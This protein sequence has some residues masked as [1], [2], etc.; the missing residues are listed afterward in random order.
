MPAPQGLLAEAWLRTPD[1]TWAR[2]QQDVS[3]VVGL[4]PPSAAETVVALTGLDARLGKLVDGASTWYAVAAS[5]GSTAEVGWAAALPLADPAL[6]AEALLD[7]SDAR[8]AGPGARTVAGM[9]VIEADAGAAPT[10]ALAGKWLVVASSESDLA[11]LGPYAFRTMPTKPAPGAAPVVASVPG[12]ALAGVVATQLG[13][14]WE[15]MRSWLQARDE[16]QRAA[17][18][19]RAPD[20]GDPRAILDAADAVVKRRIAVVGTASAARIELATEDGDVRADFSLT[21]GPDGGDA[22]TAALP[23]GTAHPLAEAPADAVLVI[24]SRDDATRRADDARELEVALDRALGSRA[25]ADDT[26]AVHAAIDDWARARG[27]WVL[28]SLEWGGEGARGLWLRT[29]A[30]SAEGASRAVRELVDLSHRHA[31]ESLLSGALHVAPSVVAAAD[32]ASVSRASLATFAASGADKHPH[33]SPPLGVAWGLHDGDLLVAAGG[34]A[35]AMLAAQAAPAKRLGDDP[36]TA[37]LVE[38]LGA[39][40]AFA[41]IARPLRLDPARGAGD[42]GLA[43]AV[44]AWGRK[45]SDAWV[46]VELGG[47]LIRELVRLKAGL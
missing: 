31:L 6:A 41:L 15:A 19:G 2:V 22:G 36:R 16:E 29:P 14:K 20:F 4:L 24:L 45:G 18:G 43:P 10:V 32:V 46:R 13:A 9:H 30:A 38:S 25:H 42:A 44:L 28:A 8:G 33:P 1:A 40:V 21:P 3:G 39:D 27:D 5:G 35:T 37:H 7:T 26:A 11:R 34:G 17:H 12:S 47:A 23:V